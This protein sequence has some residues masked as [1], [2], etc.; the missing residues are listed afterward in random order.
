M[1]DLVKV[2]NKQKQNQR[3]TSVTRKEVLKNYADK[4]IYA[5]G[6]LD[7]CQHVPPQTSHNYCHLTNTQRVLIPRSFLGG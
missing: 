4:T 6:Q 1:N 2:L 3:A 5:I 7:W